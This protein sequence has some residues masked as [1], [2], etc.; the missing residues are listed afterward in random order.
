MHIALIWQR[1]LPYHQAR[2][3]Y[4][5]A[6]LESR[7]DRLTAIEVAS[8]DHS[9]QFDKKTE[10]Y[11]DFQTITCLPTTSYHQHSVQEIHSTVLTTLQA[12]QPDVIIAPSTATPE[13]MAAIHYRM[14][15]KNVRVILMDTSYDKTNIRG[16]LTTQIK[17]VIHKNVDGALIPSATHHPYY[18]HLGIPAER[19]F[20]GL[21][22]VDN[23]YYA[24][25]AQQARSHSEET[26]ATR[27]LPRHFFLYVGR[28][29]PMKGLESLMAA[30]ARY[31]SKTSDPWQLVMVGGGPH[32]AVIKKKA[33]GIRGIHFPG[34]VMAPD[35]CDYLG[36]AQAVI[37]PSFS[38]TWGLII[39]E[40]MASS[41]PVLA[42]TACGAVPSLLK[43]G[44]NGWTFTAGDEASLTDLMVTLSQLP[45]DQ[46]AQMGQKAQETIAE[47]SLDR[48]LEGAMAV[49]HLTRRPDPN[50]LLRQ[51]ALL[52]KGR[53]R[54]T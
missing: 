41:L 53:V 50:G 27:N 36:L 12:T 28:F 45:A 46:R 11:P 40:A 34:R 23:D 10:A 25:R 13:G 19:L 16:W 38:E 21:N 29:L 5:Q 44:E 47:W 8:Q 22:V 30:F 9:Y 33:E 43:E 18:V 20:F 39:N 52:W 14:Q 54:T 4:L 31:Q 26:L 48:F 51:L 6:H 2:A 1:F 37:V 24:K 49:I 3:Q 35:L 15:T 17:R 32:E 42:S 7:G